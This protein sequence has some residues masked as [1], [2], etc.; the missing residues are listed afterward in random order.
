MT[1]VSEPII[2]PVLYLPVREHPELGHVAEIRPLAD[3]RTALISF[4]ALDRLVDACGPE[5]PW[6]L[7]HLSELEEIKAQQ[8]FE[9]VAFDPP[10]PPSAREGGRLK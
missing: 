8:P 3:G 2:P 4:T 1:S 7:V 5:Q 10:V 9:V 6:R